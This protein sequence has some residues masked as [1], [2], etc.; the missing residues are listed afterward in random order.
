MSD[1]FGLPAEV[2]SWND[3]D[4]ELLFDC[5]LQTPHPPI[6]DDIEFDFD[7]NHTTRCDEGSV[8]SSTGSP[9]YMPETQGSTFSVKDWQPRLDFVTFRQS[10]EDEAD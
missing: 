10:L 7:T 4:E 6:N 5:G 2:S 3:F 8:S 9:N 1:S